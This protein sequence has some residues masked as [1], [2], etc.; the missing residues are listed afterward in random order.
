M[1][2]SNGSSER[3]REKERYLKVRKEQRDNK[4]SESLRKNSREKK[5][6]KKKKVI[7]RILNF[8]I[9]VKSQSCRKGPNSPKSFLPQLLLGIGN[10]TFT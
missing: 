10:Q 4:E 5:K 9:E 7:G 1:R 3:E 6:R 8:S 2:G